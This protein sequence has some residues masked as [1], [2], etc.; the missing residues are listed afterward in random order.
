MDPDDDDLFD[1]EPT[2]SVQHDPPVERDDGQ[3][4]GA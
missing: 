4:P 2:R 1:D 3:D